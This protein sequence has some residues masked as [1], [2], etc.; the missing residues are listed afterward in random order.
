MTYGNYLECGIPVEDYEEQS[1]TL[2]V[3]L[4]D[5][6]LL[7]FKDLVTD[8]VFADGWLHITHENF[9]KK[10]FY[11]QIKESDVCYLS[12]TVNEREQR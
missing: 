7:I 2:W 6:D 4:K 12:Y 11:S 10:K 1:L 3:Y 8:C 5:E 9:G